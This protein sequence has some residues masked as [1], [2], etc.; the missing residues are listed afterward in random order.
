MSSNKYM[1]YVG[2]SSNPLL[3]KINS[4]KG[5]NFHKLQFKLKE[6]T[7]PSFLRHDSYLD[8]GVV[9]VLLSFDDINR[10]IVADPSRVVG[11]IIDDHKNEIVRMMEKSKSISPL[12]K[13]IV[14]SC[15][16]P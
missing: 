14:R 7:Y 16:I 4:D 10:Q 9:W 1:V 6:T 3:L 15:L 5:K 11:T 13:R 8:C 2:D 12:Q